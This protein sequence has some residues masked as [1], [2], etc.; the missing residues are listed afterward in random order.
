MYRVLRKMEKGGSGKRI[1][2]YSGERM[3]NFRPVFFLALAA[4]AAPFAALRF[5]YAALLFAVP[6]AVPGAVFVSVRLKRAKPVKG[7]AVFCVLLTAVFCAAAGGFQ[8]VRTDYERAPQFGGECLITGT[9]R[10]AGAFDH[11]MRLTLKDV[12]VMN[13]EG[14]FSPEHGM[15]AYVYG[16]D[17]YDA[18]T[19]VRFRAVIETL[20]FIQYGEV[21]ASAVLDGVRYRAEIRAE[22]AETAG[23][24]ADM[25]GSV[26]DRLRSVLFGGMDGEQASIAYAMLAGDSGMIDEGM[27]DSFRYGGVA[28]VFAVS[29]LHIGV[30][31]GLLSAVS[32]KLRLRAAVRLPVTAAVLVFYAGV[33]GFSPSSLRALIMC[34]ALALS[35]VRGLKYDGLNSLSFAALSVLLVQPVYFYQTG[36]RLSVAAAGGIIVLGG[37]LARLLKRIKIPAKLASALAVSFSAQAAAFPVMLDAFGYVSACS[38]LLNLL[39]VP[40]ASFVYSF[41][42]V[43]AWAA[44]AV[45]PLGPVLLKIPEILLVLCELPVLAFDWETLLLCGFTFGACAVLW[46]ALLFLL[47][48]KINLKA[49]PKAV[50]SACTAAALVACL[51]AENTAYGAVC[52]TMYSRYGTDLLFAER[53]GAKYLVLTGA[54]DPAYAERFF[55]REGADELDAVFLVCGAQAADGAVAAV[56]QLCGAEKYY[57]SPE[58]GYE[59][60]FR[61]IDVAEA[62]G[63]ISAD[64]M[65]AQ[66]TGGG[67]ML[68]ADGARILIAGEDAD[69]SGFYKADLLIAERYSD[70]LRAA[71]LPSAEAYFEKTP[72]KIDAYEAGDL[73]ITLKNGIISYRGRNVSYEVRYV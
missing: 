43:C 27:L 26:R 47:S 42:F 6:L 2:L 34:L 3:M 54:P 57:V 68:Y 64:G 10:D 72:G 13:A 29:G 48:D 25:F 40:L 69:V 56:S 49:V 28:H 44:C 17:F 14:Y 16:G 55:L 62:D 51:F 37:H 31:Y 38:L 15:Y 8:L 30:V 39:F 41:L 21:N 32:K 58:I 18:G 59:P 12:T 19:V 71:C 66:F 4:A 7:A 63:I 70:E 9:V 46:Y 65:Y 53:N 1:A 20:D 11:G 61:D 33:C 45:P 73:Q 36:F 50:A 35:D 60:S 22:A 52:F 5:G 24:R 23:R 67:L